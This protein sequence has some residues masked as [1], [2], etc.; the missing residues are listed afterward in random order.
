MSRT[1][2][3]LFY[4]DSD[5]SVLIRTI[6]CHYTFP[7]ILSWKY[8]HVTKHH[9]K[10]TKKLAYC[11]IIFNGKLTIKLVRIFQTPL[12]A[13]TY[14][15]KRNALVFI[16]ISFPESIKISKRGPNGCRTPPSGNKFA[17]IREL[18]IALDFASPDESHTVSTIS[19]AVEIWIHTKCTYI[20]THE[21]II[22]TT[23]VYTR[24]VGMYMP[25]C[26]CA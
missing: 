25:H 12:S 14:V 24:Y 8:E 1:R 4:S 22:Y 3:I 11:L 17:N 18:H 2:S 6:P 10:I 13:Y 7:T 21:N 16:F 9:K 19:R 26:T 20:H 23:Y 15:Q 5:S